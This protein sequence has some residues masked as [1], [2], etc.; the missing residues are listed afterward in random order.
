MRV[1]KRQFVPTVP[2]TESEIPGCLRGKATLAPCLKCSR[3]PNNCNGKNVPTQL[4]RASQA[5]PDHGHVSARAA[6]EAGVSVYRPKE[7]CGVCGRVSW[8]TLGGKCGECDQ[9]ERRPWRN[10]T[11]EQKEANRRQIQANINDPERNR[12]ADLANKD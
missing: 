6:R 4:M 7:P 12:L 8:R 5:F 1:G 2:A 11:E 9:D 10:W 3:F